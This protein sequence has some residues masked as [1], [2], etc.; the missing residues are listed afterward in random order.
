[1]TYHVDKYFDASPDHH[2]HSRSC[3]IDNS[4]KNTRKN[5]TWQISSKNKIFQNFLP[6]H[7]N[8]QENPVFD[9]KGVK[10]KIK[11]NGAIMLETVFTSSPSVNSKYLSL[12]IP[13]V[14]IPIVV[15]WSIQMYQRHHITLRCRSLKSKKE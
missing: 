7:H 15:Q 13:I 14:K 6:I 2:F 8:Y 11:R 9:V 10:T 12:K 3:C 4:N 5:T 1:M